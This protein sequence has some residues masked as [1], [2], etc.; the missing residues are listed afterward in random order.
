MSNA[1]SIISLPAE[2]YGHPALLIAGKKFWSRKDQ[3]SGTG[4]AYWVRDKEITIPKG[5]IGKVVYGSPDSVG[6]IIIKRV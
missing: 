3:N 2:T 5:S 4:P 1:K 6:R